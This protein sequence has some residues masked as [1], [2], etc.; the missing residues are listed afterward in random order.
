MDYNVDLYKYMSVI[1]ECHNHKQAFCLRLCCKDN[2]LMA[3]IHNVYLYIYIYIY[4]SI[5]VSFILQRV[6]LLTL[7]LMQI[8]YHL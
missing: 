3:V 4:V 6:L 5:Y 8:V 7:C 2:Q 1:R